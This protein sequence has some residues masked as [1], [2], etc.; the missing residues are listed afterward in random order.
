MHYTWSGAHT[1]ERGEKV[2]VLAWGIP[3]PAHLLIPDR[4]ASPSKVHDLYDQG[5]F[6]K[7]QPH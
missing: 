7:P 5:K 3:P 6:L 1:I 2:G 4:A